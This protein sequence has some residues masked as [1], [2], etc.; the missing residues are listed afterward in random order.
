MRKWTFLAAALALLATPAFGCT[1]PG[2]GAYQLATGGVLRESD[3]AFIP[4]DPSNLD[5]QCYQKW[6]AVPNSALAAPSSAAAQAQSDLAGKLAAGLAITSSAYPALDGT[7]AIDPATQS[8][9]QATALYIQVNGHFP[10]AL[11]SLPW[12]DLAGANHSFTTTA[13]FQAFATAAADYVT[14][15]N[16]Q[17]HI[18]A[19]GGTP[20]WPSASVSIP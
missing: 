19:D 1:L 20:S 3:H 11:S 2:A 8:Q 6:L 13:E 17:A 12:P 9:I 4:A 7:Y 15:I 16:L 5:W 10:A 14:Q 18:E